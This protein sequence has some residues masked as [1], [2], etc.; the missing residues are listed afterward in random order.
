[1]TIL[2]FLILG[3]ANL[4]MAWLNIHHALGNKRDKPL[5]YLG[6][7]GAAICLGSIINELL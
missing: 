5:A 6:I 3:V 7:L 4:G 2:V 1:M